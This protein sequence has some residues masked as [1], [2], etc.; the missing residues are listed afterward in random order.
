M[1]QNTKAWTSDECRQQH[2]DRYVLHGR[3]LP[4]SMVKVCSSSWWVK[5]KPFSKLSIT[6]GPMLEGSPSLAISDTLCPYAWAFSRI[7]R[8]HFDAF[9][10]IALRRL[11]RILA[12]AWSLAA[13][14]SVAASKAAFLPMTSTTASPI[15]WATRTS[16]SCCT[17]WSRRFSHHDIPFGRKASATVSWIGPEQTTLL[18][19]PPPSGRG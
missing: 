1:D 2:K 10:E 9:C 4:K 14:S 19:G 13:A 16:V 18:P 7:N 8:E 15:V 17:L 6:V 5:R 12:F 3:L 11:W